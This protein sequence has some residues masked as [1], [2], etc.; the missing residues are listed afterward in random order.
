MFIDLTHNKI[1]S[2]TIS[3]AFKKSVELKL[4]PMLEERFG[5]LLGIQMY[6]D[7]IADGFLADGEWYYPLTLVFDS[8]NKTL[9]IKWRISRHGFS[10]G[11]PYA[12]TGEE[13]ID[14]VIADSVPEAFREAVAGRAVFCEDGLVPLKIDASAKDPAFLSGK[15]SQTFVDEMARQLTREIAA[16]QGVGTLSGSTI[17]LR[18]V[19]APETYMEHTSESVTYRRLLLT[20]KGC[21]PRDFWVKWTRLDSATAYTVSDSPAPGTITFEIGEDVPQKV[22]ERE[23]RFLVRVDGDKFHNAMSRKN[24]TE[25]REILRRAIRRGDIIKLEEDEAL[26]SMRDAALREQ[27]SAILGVT[28]APATEPVVEDNQPEEEDML[29]RMAREAIMGASLRDEEPVTVTVGATDEDATCDTSDDTEIYLSADDENADNLEDLLKLDGAPDEA[30]EQIALV[31]EPTVA[32]DD[33]PET[34]APAFIA[35]LDKEIEKLEEESFGELKLDEEPAIEETPE[36]E[37][38]PKLDT[39]VVDEERIRREIE[40]KLRLEY[41]ARARAAAEEEAAR[42]RREQEL[43]RRENERLVEKARRDAEAKAAEEARLKAEIEAQLRQEA[44]EKER[45]AEAAMLAMEERR[46]LEA[47]RAEAERIRRENEAKAAEERRI[48][49][50]RAR[51]EVERAKE[52]ERIRRE[53]QQAEEVAKTL[54]AQGAPKYISRTAEFTFRRIVDPNITKRIYEIVKATIEFYHK[55]DVYIRIKA[56]VPD[57]ATVRLEFLEVPEEEGELIVNIIKALGKSDLG[58]AKATLD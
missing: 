26:S 53:R 28:P 38:T 2:E 27:L 21:A 43:L 54:E 29:V 13:L 57:N 14:F 19:F 44:R 8:S 24:V 40:A 55:E 1:I 46:R 36:V 20:D 30:E 37:E 34:L 51:I 39:P 50:E 41:E 32:P 3:A 6:E 12:Y 17:E 31:A 56:S 49:E 48:A 42:L 45:L 10:G 22:R 5:G 4:V 58:I 23:Y 16:S 52:A 35:A 33:E 9:W 7:H 25:W 15:Y 47:E 11:N 18:L